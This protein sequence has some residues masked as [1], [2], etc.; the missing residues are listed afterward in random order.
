MLRIERDGACGAR[1]LTERP[2]RAGQRILRLSDAALSPRPS[3]YTVQIGPDA[4]IDGSALGDLAFLN[5]ACDP[6]TVIDT[7]ARVLLAL[8]DLAPG[9]ELTFFYPS[10]EWEMNHPFTCR[11][12]APQCIRLVAGAK[13]LPADV[14]GRYF[15]NPHIRDLL[16][17]AVSAPL[18]LREHAPG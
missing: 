12:G 5:H 17:A 2:F 10:T 1:L 8:R 3:T 13:F 18:S 6:S 16:L 14:L 4:H 15:I 11:C 7:E 9:D